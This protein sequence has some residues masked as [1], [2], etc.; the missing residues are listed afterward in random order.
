MPWA[1]ALIRAQTR[2]SVLSS[3]QGRVLSYVDALNEALSIAMEMDK[4]VIV[5]GQGV[6]DPA[7]GFRRYQRPAGKVRWRESF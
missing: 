5:L 7:A 2:E 6:D 3:E 4:K 1:E